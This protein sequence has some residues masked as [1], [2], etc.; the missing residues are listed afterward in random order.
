MNYRRRQLRTDCPSKVPGR[1][2]FGCLSNRSTL[3]PSR[4][5]AKPAKVPYAHGKL[6]R[7][8]PGRF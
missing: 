5:N 2:G 1:A 3:V 7:I 6:S 8:I 4:A